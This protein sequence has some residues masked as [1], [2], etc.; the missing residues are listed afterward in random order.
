MLDSITVINAKSSL[1]FEQL[2]LVIYSS[3]FDAAGVPVLVTN[4]AAAA[5][6]LLRMVTNLAEAKTECIR[7]LLDVKNNFHLVR[8]RAAFYFLRDVIHVFAVDLEFDAEPPG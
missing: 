5:E 7:R 6:T 2:I 3:D 4:F 1:S 8:H